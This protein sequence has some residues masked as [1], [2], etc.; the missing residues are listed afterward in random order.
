MQKFLRTLINPDHDDNPEM[1]LI[2]RAA[3]ILQIGEFQL[4]QLAYNKWHGS[5]IATTELDRLFGDYMLRQQVTH[6]MRH[7]ARTIIDGYE[8]GEIDIDNPD[9]HRYD[10]TYTRHVHDGRKKFITAA[11][12]LAI[13]IFG[14][15]FLSHWIVQDKGSIFPPYFGHEDL[16]KQ[17]KNSRVRIPSP[18]P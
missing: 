14:S 1:S 8:S 11:L 7:Y 17:S 13:A 3:N 4:L 6:W 16:D 18:L 5:E 10:H 12:L 15:I 2:A 9:F